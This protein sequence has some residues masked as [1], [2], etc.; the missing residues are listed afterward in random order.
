V[1]EGSCRPSGMLLCINM[2]RHGHQ[3]CHARRP[4]AQHA[5]GDCVNFI[6][7]NP[8]GRQ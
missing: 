2:V 6:S 8:G 7:G 1:L 3:V 4:N 5:L